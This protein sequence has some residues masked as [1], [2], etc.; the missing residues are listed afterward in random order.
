V[1]KNRDGGHIGQRHVGP[2][3]HLS[4]S[5]SAHMCPFMPTT[6]PSEVLNEED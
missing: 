4:S 5:F 1:G 6:T 2:H 3:N